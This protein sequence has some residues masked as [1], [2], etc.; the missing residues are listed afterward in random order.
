MDIESPGTSW[1]SQL[2]AEYGVNSSL[3]VA[4]V[5][6]YLIMIMTTTMMILTMM[7]VTM[8]IVMI[9]ADAT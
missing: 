7:I 3:E 6:A 4:Q 1:L 2:T 5:E 9:I 8:M